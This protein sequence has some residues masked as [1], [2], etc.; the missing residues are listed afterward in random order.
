MPLHTNSHG[1][2]S[3]RTKKDGRKRA[4]STASSSATNA[5]TG[6]EKHSKK[7]PNGSE[8]LLNAQAAS[9]CSP[10]EPAKT[11]PN[12]F[13]FLDE[14]EGSSSGSSESEDENGSTV[15]MQAAPE[16]QSP[17]PRTS[18]A[19]HALLALK[20]NNSQKPSKASTTNGASRRPSSSQP[21]PTSSALAAAETQLQL[22]RKQSQGQDGSSR[23]N[24]PSPAKRQLQLSRTENH[25]TSRDSNAIHRPPLP[26][27]PPSSPEDSL[28]RITTRRDSSTSHI[29]SGY[30]LIASHLTR[31]AT[32]DKASFPPIYRRFESLN[33]R[34]LLHLQDEISQMEEELQSLDEYEE[35]HRVASAEKDGTKPMPASRRVEV[36]SQAYSSLHYRRMELMAALVQKTERYSKSSID[37]HRK[38]QKVQPI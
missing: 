38:L 23:G 24:S 15:P 11:A 5:Q 22:A 25:Y 8:H 37:V 14:N 36:Q 35:M 9:E 4:L 21:A 26:P 3:K 34:V 6:L 13:E 33:H 17:K 19:P 29:S 2:R 12:V 1:L 7:Q 30:G 20:P 16:I 31:S 10:E 27:S 18:S 28:H 32:Q